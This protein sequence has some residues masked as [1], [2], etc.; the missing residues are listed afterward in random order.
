MPEAVACTG[1]ACASLVSFGAAA[2]ALS[3]EALLPDSWLPRGTNKEF[4]LGWILNS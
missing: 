4:K 2:P 3:W 1:A